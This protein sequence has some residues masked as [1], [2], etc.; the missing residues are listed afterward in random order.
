M[1]AGFVHADNAV[2]T[3]INVST[4]AIG[5]FTGTICQNKCG[6]Y[7]DNGMTLVDSAATVPIE[8]AAHLI[9]NYHTRF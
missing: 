7:L 5:E 6:H 3:I 2:I 1:H 9:G 4:G 8:A